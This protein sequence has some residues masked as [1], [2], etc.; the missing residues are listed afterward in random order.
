MVA[1]GD[2]VD[3]YSGGTPPK[4]RRDLWAGEVPWFSAKDIKSPRL[5]DSKDHISAA[6]FSETTLRRIP[7]GTVTLVARGMILAHTVP[8]TVIE[9]SCAINQ[10]LRA[11]LPKRDIDSIFLQA[12]LKAQHRT[13]LNRVST[14][15]HGTKKLDLRALQ[16]IEIPL[17]P[18]YE[19]RRIAA[20]LDR[21]NKQLEDSRQ[22]SALLEALKQAM[23]HKMFSERPSKTVPLGDLIANHQLGLDKKTSELGPQG[24]FPYL[25][26]DS[27]TSTGG[28]DLSRTPR[29]DCSPEEAAKYSLREGDLIFNTRNARNL[30]GKSTVYRGPATI[31]NNNI[32]R[33]RFTRTVQPDFIHQFLW[34]KNGRQQLDARKSGTTSVWAIYFK[35]LKTV[36]VPVPE[37]K[38]QTEFA[39]QL[40]KLRDQIQYYREREASL[41]SLL[42]SLQVRAFRGEL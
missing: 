42:N 34:S 10:D 32:L 28:L 37:L 29:V 20:I 6:A 12:V 13:L 25:K 3:C 9:T 21:A 15:A 8:I 22:A 14:A 33:L 23:F 11:L 30:V 27:I 26:M 7:A 2:V 4:A 40:R 41:A 39:I 18:I 5:R 1:L 31:F 24:E 19:Q 35:S 36:Q 16:S 38:S 17:P